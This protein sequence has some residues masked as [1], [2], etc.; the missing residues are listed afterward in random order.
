VGDD[1]E[2]RAVGVDA[3]EQRGDL[4]A[5]G[6]IELAGRLVGQQK[7]GTVGERSRDRDALHLTARE[8]RGSMIGARAETD[9]LEQ[10]LRPFPSFDLRNPGFR[11]RE[12]DVL[13]RGEH[14][15]QEEALEDESDLAEPQQA[16]LAIGERRHVVALKE[17]PSRGGRLDAAQHVEQRGFAAA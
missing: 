5:R 16:A 8:L 15:Q 7:S 3:V 13:P 17:Q 11:L 14:R 4:F 9:V 6:A 1:D 2:R 12:L 10:L